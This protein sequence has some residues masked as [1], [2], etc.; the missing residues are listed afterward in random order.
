LKEGDQVTVDVFVA[1]NGA[2]VGNL[3]R[4][5]FTDGKELTTR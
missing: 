4:I 2:P 5:V 1:K 3:Q